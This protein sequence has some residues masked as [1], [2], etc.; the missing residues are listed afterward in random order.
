M[1]TKEKQTLNDYVCVKLAARWVVRGNTDT[2][3]LPKQTFDSLVRIERFRILMNDCYSVNLEPVPRDDWCVKNLKGF[4]DGILDRDTPFH[5]WRSSL[6]R[7]HAC[8]KTRTGAA[9]SLFLFRKTLP[10]TSSK[11]NN[12]KKLYDYVLKMTTP[13]PPLDPHFAAFAYAETRRIFKRRWDRKWSVGVGNFTLPVSS[14]IENRRS[15]GGARNLNRDQLREAFN[16]FSRGAPCDLGQ[17]TVPMIVPTGGKDRLVTQF[18]CLRSFLKPLHDVMYRHLTDK[19]DWCLRGDVDPKKVADFVPVEGEIFVSGDYESA[20]DNLNMN[21][22]RLMLDGIRSNSTY[23]PDSVWD[24]AMASVA[25][26][27]PDGETQQH[28]QLMGSLLCFPLLCLAN[29]LSFRYIIRRPV[30]VLINGDDIVF[31]CRTN[32]KDAWVESVGK[33]GLVL[34]LGKTMFHRSVFSLNSTYFISSKSSSPRFAPFIRSSCLFN[35]VEDCGEIAGRL[36]GCVVGTGVF[37]EKVQTFLLRNITRGV[38]STQRSLR[39]GLGCTLS[40][41]TIRWSQMS[42][43]E[44]FYLSFPSEPSLPLRKKLWMHNS[45]PDGYVR[46]AGVPDD[47]SFS[48]NMIETAW[49]RPPLRRGKQ[50]DTEYWDY[51]RE[52]TYRYNPF[53]AYGFWAMAG[54]V[55]ELPRPSL[56]CARPVKMGWKKQREGGIAFV[57]AGFMR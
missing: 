56:Q 17:L 13:S 27:F 3:A 18:S 37:R 38:F 43:R 6:I 10:S 49:E 44:D 26:K 21:L 40:N 35:R 15:A 16:D 32:E 19:T 51:V 11:E 36:K 48:S 53:S 52:G 12:E 9:A 28:G 29:Y 54:G 47:E 23:I 33:S 25:N 5:S 8:R 50:T 30:P 55:G 41:R 39:R 22:T 20:S 24:A 34:S 57:S 14:C 7:S 45:I 2:R 31:R 46:C 42:A 4:C 1:K